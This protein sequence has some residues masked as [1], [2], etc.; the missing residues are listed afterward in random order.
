MPR[1]PETS[2]HRA[3][4]STPRPSFSV[5]V[6]THRRP[7]AL[8]RCL[9]ALRSLDLE[10]ANL[11]IIVVEDGGPAP[12]LADLRETARGRPRVVFS[13]QPHRGPAAARNLGASLATHEYL[14]FTDD[15][16]CPRPD[17]LSAFARELKEAPE[18]VV[19]GE[20]VN[21]VSDNV[22]SIAS[23]DLVNHF[24]LVQRRL[25][26]PF[27]SSN[28][29]AMSRGTYQRLAGFDESFALAGGEDRDLCRRALDLG[30]ELRHVPDARIDHHHMLSWRSF[31]RQQYHYGRGARL[32]HRK[33]P[34]GASRG[35]KDRLGFYLDMVFHPRRGKRVA[36]PFAVTLLRAVSQLAVSIGYMR[37]ALAAGRRRGDERDAAK[38]DRRLF[39]QRTSQ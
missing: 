15:D 19:G 39:P 17:W 27:F 22:F 33:H 31:W 35:P 8:R 29:L 38:G 7:E 3:G 2:S 5:V 14:A 20:T 25:G 37:E 6:P 34:G 28:N 36:H 13:S 26:A 1:S 9:S 21:T 4:A 24:S 18:C 30:L 12:E 11:E 32:Y 16:C 10:G 23:Q